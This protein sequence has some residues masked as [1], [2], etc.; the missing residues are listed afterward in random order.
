M[1][2]FS[3]S[4]CGFYEDGH[5]APAPPD[6]IAITA[7]ER[8]RALADLRPGHR[9]VAGDDGKP[10]VAAAPLSRDDV[11]AV[12]RRRRNVLLAACD[13]TQAADSPIPD[14]ARSAWAAY[15]QALRD[16]PG[17]AA[18]LTPLAWPLPPA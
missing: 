17:T 16:L 3:P 8:D 2:Y 5:G 11:L 10:V 18:D 9:I 7:D 13:W 1:I 4:T 15:R 12:I 14:T 6:A